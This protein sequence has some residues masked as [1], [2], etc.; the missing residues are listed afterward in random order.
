ML[1]VE[2]SSK[3]ILIALMDEKLE[4]RAKFMGLELNIWKTGHQY[5]NGG[6]F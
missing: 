3:G 5:D 4:F 1:I 2:H 6:Y